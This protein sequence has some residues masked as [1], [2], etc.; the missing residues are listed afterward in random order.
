[1]NREQVRDCPG[2][3]TEDEWRNAVW[4]LEAKLRGPDRNCKCCGNWIGLSDR[5]VVTETE[6]WMPSESK[7]P[8]GRWGLR[9]H[10]AT[11]KGARRLQRFLGPRA[12]IFRMTERIGTGASYAPL[13]GVQA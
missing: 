5:Y 4:E 1:M 8:R 7:L 11:L 13:S 6:S 9:V 10:A 12:T 2:N 3:R